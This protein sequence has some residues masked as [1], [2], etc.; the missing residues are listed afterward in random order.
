MG[1]KTCPVCKGDK[2]VSK[3]SRPGTNNGIKP[4]ECPNCKGRG[5]I[6]IGKVW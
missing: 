2:T 4:V 6:V 1:I 5:Y 3:Q